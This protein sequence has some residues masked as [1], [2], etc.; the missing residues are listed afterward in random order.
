MSTRCQ[1]L[2]PQT[3]TTQHTLSFIDLPFLIFLFPFLLCPYFFMYL[4]SGRHPDSSQGRFCFSTPAMLPWSSLSNIFPFRSSPRSLLP[5][6]YHTGGLF[7]GLTWALGPIGRFGY[8]SCL[9]KYNHCIGISPS[10]STPIHHV[11]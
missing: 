2:Q 9:R 7:T 4:I 1:W 6:S 11:F 10:S 5:D 8:I 3:G